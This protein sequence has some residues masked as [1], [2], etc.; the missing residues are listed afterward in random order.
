MYVDDTLLVTSFLDIFR[1]FQF[2]FNFLSRAGES[3]GSAGRTNSATSA[4]FPAL[5]GNGIAMSQYTPSQ[6][7]Q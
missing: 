5:I 2:V 3:S 4:N 1:N 6:D 7:M